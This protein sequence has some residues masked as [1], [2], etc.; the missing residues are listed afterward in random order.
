[1]VVYGAGGFAKE[2]LQV[3]E[4]DSYNKKII[5][6]DN[7]NTN[8]SKLFNKY[9]IYSKKDDVEFYFKN[10]NDN[11]CIGIGNPILR[12]ETCKQFFNLGGNFKTII[13]SKSNIGFHNVVIKD[14]VIVLPGVNISNDVSIGTG[15][16]IY[17][18]SNITHDCV[19]GEFVEISPSVNLLGN[20]KVGGYSSL[21]TNCTILPGIT[22]GKRVTV[23]AGCVVTMDIPDDKI[24]V[25]VP[26]KII[27]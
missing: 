19:I 13:S 2:V 25:G 6:F 24:V 18:N 5:F 3:L 10:V 22:I 8:K 26:G 11:F 21:G 23:G 9:K 4:S 12:S 14:G 17:Y 1:M 7:I 27:N 16:M 15:S 20:V